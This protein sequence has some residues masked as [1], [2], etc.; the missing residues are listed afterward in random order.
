MQTEPE[1]P[2]VYQP[3]GVN[4]NGGERLYGIGGI[5]PCGAVQVTVRGLT[6]KEADAVCEVLTKV[7]AGEPTDM[8]KA[9]E[10]MTLATRTI[11][12][13]KAEVEQRVADTISVEA[14]YARL[15]A[16]V[17]RLRSVLTNIQDNLR[18]HKDGGRTQQD[19]QLRVI[20]DRVESVLDAKDP[21]P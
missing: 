12:E 15:K 10:R 3:F 4:E 9:F 13:L 18:N 21:T 8:N 11:D 20:K 2:Y 7:Q 17:E 16:E 1:Q 14:D 6:R 5:H 19:F